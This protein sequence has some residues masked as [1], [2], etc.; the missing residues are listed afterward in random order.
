[1]CQRNRGFQSHTEFFN[2]PLGSRDAFVCMRLCL[3][4]CLIIRHECV[5]LINHRKACDPW[6]KKKTRLLLH[7][8][9]VAVL[10]WA[11]RADA[12]FVN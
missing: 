11:Q 5:H 9:R 12:C 6:K 2:F 1:M 7:Q 4:Y 3:Y 8:Q 10:G